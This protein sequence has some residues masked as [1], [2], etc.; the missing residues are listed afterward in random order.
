LVETLLPLF[1]VGISYVSLVKIVVN[2]LF[3][4]YCDLKWIS[5][6]SEG[7]TTGG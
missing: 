4:M 2:I 7:R 5:F 1:Q 3:E 6:S